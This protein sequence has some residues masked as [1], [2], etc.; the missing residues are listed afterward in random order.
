VRRFLY[1]SPFVGLLVMVGMVLV[2]SAAEAATLYLC[3]KGSWQRLYTWNVW[4]AWTYTA[5]G[6]YCRPA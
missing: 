6:W 2:A 4:T 3:T 1:A 5:Q